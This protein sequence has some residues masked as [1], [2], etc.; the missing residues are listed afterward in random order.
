MVKTAAPITPEA[1]HRTQDTMPPP[2]RSHL[3]AFPNRDSPAV[4]RMTPSFSQERS[5]HGS[6][7]DVMVGH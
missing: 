4:K 6:L 7:F 2:T 1:A 3:N 5:G